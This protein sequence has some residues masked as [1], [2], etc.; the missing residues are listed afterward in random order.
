MT[1]VLSITLQM[2]TYYVYMMTNRRRVVLYTGITNSLE[3]RCWYHQCENPK[4]FTHHYK[5]NRLVY[6]EQFNDA[7][8]AIG[9]EKQIKGWR[10]E[11]KDE[12]VRSINPT[13]KDLKLELF[14]IGSGKTTRREQNQ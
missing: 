13:W 5:A 12:L 2:K 10:R 8:S 6:Y 14:G 11:K 7:Q 4:S 1:R 9:R 3:R